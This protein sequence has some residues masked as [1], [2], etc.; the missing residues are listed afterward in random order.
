MPGLAIGLGDKA[1]SPRFETG[2]PVFPNKDAFT[3]ACG[4]KTGPVRVIDP[5]NGRPD[6]S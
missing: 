3:A 6:K 1:I 4:V 2:T 5:G